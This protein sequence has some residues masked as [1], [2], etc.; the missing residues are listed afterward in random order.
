MTLKQLDSATDSR[1]GPTLG[2]LTMFKLARLCEGLNCTRLADQAGRFMDL[3]CGG[4]SQLPAKARPYWPSD[5]TDDGTPIEFSVACEAGRVELRLLAEPQRLPGTLLSNWDEGLSVNQRLLTEH[6]ATL[7]RFDRVRDIFAPCASDAARFA[8]WHAAVLG[9]GGPGFKAYLNPRIKG[10]SNAPDL[11]EN[12][13][14]ALALPDAWKF[15]RHHQLPPGQFVYFS[16]DLLAAEQA[17]VKVYAAYELS[18]VEAL[19]GCLERSGLVAKQ[20]MMEWTTSL[21]GTTPALDD[22]GIQI[23]YSFRSRLDKPEMT[24]YVPVRNHCANDAM[25]LESAMQFMPPA[26]R[27]TVTTAVRSMA[28]RELDAGRGLITYV[29]LRPAPSGLRTTLYLSPEVYSIAAP[30]PAS[31]APRGARRHSGIRQ[32]IPGQ[33]HESMPFGE[34]MKIVEARRASLAVHPL[35]TWLRSYEGSLTDVQ[36]IAARVAFFVMSFQDVLRLV[37][38]RTSDPF[39]S[40]LAADHEQEDLGHDRWY[41]QDLERLGVKVTLRD[42]F[43]KEASAVR[44]IAY[45]QISDVLGSRSDC[46]RLGVVLALEAAGAEFF[47]SMIR[48]VERQNRSNG[49]SY[50]ARRHQRVEQSHEILADEAQQRLATMPVPVSEVSEVLAVVDRTFSTMVSLADHLS[51]EL[52]DSIDA[53]GVHR[54]EEGAA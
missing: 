54:L 17:R 37:R 2:D 46:S 18:D 14:R 38:V 19:A 29:A 23:C 36:R 53:A 40:G 26:S 4:W 41:L 16:L 43:S 28:G 42:L 34:V 10:A 15:L 24:L 21:A 12:A 39:L 44:D 30:R 9:Q 33:L 31:S 45:T 27:E 8:L 48:F 35:L 51:S 50:F 6:G 3:V 5:I 13:L 49:L 1:V 52:G 25:A 20:Q 22:R 7:D 32:L 47:E 11:V